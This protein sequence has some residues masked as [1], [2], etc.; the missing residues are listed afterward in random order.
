MCTTNINV[1][2]K[3]CEH[4]TSEKEKYTLIVS[5]W[6]AFVKARDTSM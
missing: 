3:N 5:A 2:G 6:E 4:A 1:C